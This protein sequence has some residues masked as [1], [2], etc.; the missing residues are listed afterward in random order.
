MQWAQVTKSLKFH[1]QF[2]FISSSSDVFIFN[3]FTLADQQVSH[4]S[5]LTQM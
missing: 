1:I 2:H 4:I 5:E 3:E